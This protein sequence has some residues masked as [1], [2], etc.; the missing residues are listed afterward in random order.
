VVAGGG[1]RDHHHQ[2]VQGEGNLRDAPPRDPDTDQ[3]HQEAPADV[4]ARHRG[5]GVEPHAAERARVVPREA[6]RVGDAQP[7]DEARWGGRDQY[8]GDRRDRNREQQ[9]TAQEPVVVAVARSQPDE[10][11]DDHRAEADE[12]VEIEEAP[13]RQRRDRA[14]H[15]ALVE[16]VCRTLDRDQLVGIRERALRASDRDVAQQQVAAVE[17]HP[18]PELEACEASCAS[19][20]HAASI[21]PRSGGVSGGSQRLGVRKSLPVVSRAGRPG[22]PARA[23]DPRWRAAGGAC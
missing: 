15:G 11:R 14:L 16:E 13:D 2:R 5:I 1:D 8:V 7:R 9:R 18:E 21:A 4:H 19:E 22:R 12:V 23:G 20:C 3:R 6:D 17:G 10:G